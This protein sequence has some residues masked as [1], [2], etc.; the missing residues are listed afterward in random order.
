VRPEFLYLVIR[1]SPPLPLRFRSRL[2]SLQLAIFDYWPRPFAHQCPTA[3]LTR[4]IAHFDVSNSRPDISISTLPLS[5]T[6]NGLLT[7]NLQQPPLFFCLLLCCLFR[8]LY[9]YLPSPFFLSF[10]LIFVIQ[11]IPHRFHSEAYVVHIE[12]WYDTKL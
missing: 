4:D 3:S 5:L 2:S 10:L 1:S 6:Y 7:L 9:L 12:S 11:S 8:L